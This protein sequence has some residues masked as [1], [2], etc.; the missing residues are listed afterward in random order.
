MS[1]LPDDYKAPKSSNHYMK[2]QEGENKIRILTKP[3]IGWEDWID[4]KPIRYKNYEKPQKPN[5]PQKPIKHFWAFIVWNYAEE[6]IQILHITQATIRYAIEGLSKDSE[7]KAPY[8]YDIKI[9]KTGEGKETEYTV[10]PSPHKKLSQHIKDAFYEKR[11]YLEA[12]YDNADPFSKEWPTY[13]EGMFEETQE[14]KKNEMISLEQASELQKLIDSCSEQYQDQLWKTLRKA[15]IEITSIEELPL[16]LYDRIR[17]AAIKKR[18]EH[19]EE[20]PKH[21]NVPF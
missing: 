8:F 19:L 21:A 18:E 9:I 2:L 6:Q 12:L 1:F 15:P 11:C 20:A 10:N 5:D 3:I 17:S 4:K 14:N 16:N 7:W 13:T